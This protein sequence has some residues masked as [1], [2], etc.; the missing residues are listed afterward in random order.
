MRVLFKSLTVLIILW[1]CNQS[2]NS[3]DKFIGRWQKITDPS[4]NFYIRK[5]GVNFIF[6]M[7]NEGYPGERIP[8]S[9]N[10]EL[11]KL[12]LAIRGSKID[13]IYD[14]TTHHLISSDGEFQQYVY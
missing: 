9:Y 2:K 12:E 7:H 3:S 13:Y 8:A 14:Q 5:S 4:Y 6:E 1:A 11:D 10:K